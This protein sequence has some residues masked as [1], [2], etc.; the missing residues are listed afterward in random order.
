MKLIIKSAT[1]SFRD[2]IDTQAVKNALHGHRQD[3]INALCAASGLSFTQDSLTVRCGYVDK[4]PHLSGRK[5]GPALFINTPLGSP[6]EY[7]EVLS[8]E[9]AHRLLLGNGIEPPS[10]KLHNYYAHQYIDLFLHDSW[11]LFLSPE[12]V[13]ILDSYEHYKEHPQFKRAWNWAMKMTLQERQRNLR[14][15][16]RDKKL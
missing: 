16:I 15:L 7:M 2:I 9:L 1:T 3:I 8:H 6:Y 4:S 14:R 12:K 13:A 11:G 5:G 10:G